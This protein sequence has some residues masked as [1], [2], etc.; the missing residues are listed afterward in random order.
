MIIR[1]ALTRTQAEHA[2]RHGE[3][4]DSV[5]AAAPKVAVVLTQDW[6]GQWMAMDTYLD[7]LAGSDPGSDGNLTVFHLV[8]NTVDYFQDFLRFKEGTWG[9]ALIPYVRYYR[10]GRLVGESNFVSQGQFLRYFEA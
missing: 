8:Y 1:K 7:Q 3:F 4:D 9:N 6:C 10:D 5:T 2:M